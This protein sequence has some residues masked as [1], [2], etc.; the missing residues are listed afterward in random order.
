MYLARLHLRDYRNFA[1]QVLELPPQG[2]AIIGDNGQG[3]TNLLEA[4]YYLEIFRSF[5]GAPDEQLVRFGEEVFRVE[6]RLLAPDGTERSVAAAFERRRRRKKVTVDGAEPERLGDALGRV[7]AVIFS[8]SDV[9]LV[10][11]GPGQRRRFLDIVLS[12]AD[13]GYLAAL[14]R[15]RQALFQRNTL[16]RQGSPAELVAAWNEGLVASGSRV[17]AARARWV[18]ES[19]EGF[20]EHYAR[21]A[22]GQP[23]SVAFVSSIPELPDAPSADDIAGGFREQLERTAERER[24]RGMT[25]VG[26]HR[27]DLRFTTTGEDGVPLDL[28]TYGSGGQQRTAAIALRMVEAETIRQTRGRES[29]ILLD[30]VFAELDPGRSRRIIEWIDAAEGG[31]VILTSPKPADVQIHGDTLP[32]WRMEG[33][34]VR[35]A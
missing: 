30:D 19:R 33:G 1:E 29:V 7:G 20:A 24:V 22:G 31:Q 16:L 11:G 14:Q 35:T 6:G 27:D 12:L 26:P 25:L 15:Y 5:R 28:R 32:R 17:V 23:G 2:V 18:A 21:V 9:E 10:A 4:I 8:P 34:V 3:K 13:R